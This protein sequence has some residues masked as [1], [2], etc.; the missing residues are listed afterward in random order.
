MRYS[1]HRITS[2]N[3][4]YTKLLRQEPGGFNFTITNEVTGSSVKDQY[5]SGTCWSFSGMGLVE[6]EMIR[7][8]K[9][10]VDI[11]E[12]YV[13][14]MCYEE[15]AMNYVRMHGECTF[16]EGGAIDDV[17]KVYKKYGLMP[18]KLYQGLNYGEEKHNHNELEAVLKERNNFV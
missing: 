10:P 9:E 13:V 17:I 11:S 8:G 12:M 18:E 14:R 5:L 2:Y 7:M 15:K 3:V 1:L 4:C 6:A 16:S